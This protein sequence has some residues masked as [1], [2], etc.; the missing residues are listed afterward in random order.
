MQHGTTLVK[1]EGKHEKKVLLEELEAPE[2]WAFRDDWE[3]DINRGV[4]EEGKLMRVML[5]D[6]IR[7]NSLSLSLPSPPLQVGNTPLRQG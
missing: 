4:D 1:Y 7:V 3:V 2:G 6:T 5:S